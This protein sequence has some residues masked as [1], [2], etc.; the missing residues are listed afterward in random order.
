MENQFTTFRYFWSISSEETW[1]EQM[2]LRGW[3]LKQV[4]RFGAYTFDKTAPEKRV[5]KIDYRTFRS[6]LD[7]AEYLKLFDDSGWQ[8][9]MDQGT[10]GAYYFSSACEDASHDIFSDDESRA[11]RNLRY[12]NLMLFSLIPAFLPLFILYI[13]GS[14]QFTNVGYQ[15]P[16]LW[17]TSSLEFIA[18][19]LF[20]TPFVVVRAAIYFLPLI[21]I[22]FGLFFYLRYYMLYRQ[23]KKQQV[24]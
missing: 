17:E 24:F 2:A 14:I 21:P 22:V 18:K 13:T 20:E 6:P 7:Q 5:Y 3:R 16:G 11:H 23:A 12:A 4:S 1:L 10:N 15:T 9:V 19:F 8:P